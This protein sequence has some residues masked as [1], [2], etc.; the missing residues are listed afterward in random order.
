MISGILLLRPR[1]SKNE[2]I[3]VLNNIIETTRIWQKFKES[4]EKAVLET[5]ADKMEFKFFHMAHTVL[6]S[7]TSFLATSC[8]AFYASAT[9]TKYHW[10]S[11]LPSV[12]CVAKP[13]FFY[14]PT[15]WTPNYPLK[16]LSGRPYTCTSALTALAHNIWEWSLCVFLT[17][18]TLS[19]QGKDCLIYLCI[20]SGNTVIINSII[21]CVKPRVGME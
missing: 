17:H 11:T 20:A 18:R 19:S 21:S 10:F 5:M 16:Q 15:F 4:G 9:N 3:L 12:S 1:L 7:P 2:L 8:L 13:T 6:T 14:S